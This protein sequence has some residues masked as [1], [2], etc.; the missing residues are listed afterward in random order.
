MENV[1]T[2]ATSGASKLVTGLLAATGTVIVSIAIYD[3]FLKNSVAKL[4][5]K[6]FG[7]V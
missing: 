6:M 5:A 4:K 3:L 1:V 2:K 7:T